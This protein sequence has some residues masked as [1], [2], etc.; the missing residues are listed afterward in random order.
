MCFA[1]VASVKLEPVALEHSAH[2]DRWIAVCC[3][4]IDNE[5][6]EDTGRGAD[7]EEAAGLWRRAHEPVRGATWND[8]HLPRPERATLA[9]NIEV[10][11]PL[12]DDEGLLPRRVSMEGDAGARR[13]DRL[14]H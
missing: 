1:A 9:G 6:L 11:A 13:L 2:V 3:A 12:E 7:R 14:E 4:D 5:R 10:E 8:K